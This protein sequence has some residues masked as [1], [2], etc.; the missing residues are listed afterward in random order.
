MVDDDRAAGEE[1]VLVQYD[2]STLHGLNGGPG[3]RAQVHAGMRRT[4]LAV[5]YP[6]APE[7]RRWS[8]A[9]ERDTERPVPERLLRH[10]PEQRGQTRRFPRRAR[11]SR[12][13]KSTKR[14]GTWR[15]SSGKAT[16]S[17]DS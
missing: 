12:G 14:C 9:F 1:Q 16:G 10:G 7:A 6:T 8:D 15:C 13:L 11:L 3:R 5:E 4:R 2:P 17:T